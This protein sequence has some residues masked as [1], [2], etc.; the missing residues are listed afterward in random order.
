MNKMIL[1]VEDNI[2]YLDML[3]KMLKD[4]GYE[5]TTADNGKD[6]LEILKKNDPSIDIIITDLHMPS[7][8][9]LEMAKE[10][11]SKKISEAPIIV[12]TTETSI[13]M[14]KEGI[15]AGVHHW[16]I[17]PVQKEKFLG[18]VDLIYERYCQNQ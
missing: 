3:K 1:L 2:E 14:R 12:L 17:K 18:T 16:I 6:G 11:F 10:V 8:N 9:G 7:L 5:V 13:K 15:E 4:H